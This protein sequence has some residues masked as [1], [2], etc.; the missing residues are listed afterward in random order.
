MEQNTQLMEGQNDGQETA[1]THGGLQVSTLLLPGM[2][3]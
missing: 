2:F 1:A 3:E